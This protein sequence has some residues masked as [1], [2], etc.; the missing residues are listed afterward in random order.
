MLKYPRESFCH[1]VLFEKDILEVE[2]FCLFDQ[3][4]VKSRQAGL[5]LVSFLFVTTLAE[6][7][8]RTVFKPVI[9]ENATK[10][11][12]DVGGILDSQG[13]PLSKGE[14]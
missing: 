5:K 14:R 7:P 13:C 6:R 4:L 9:I 12:D 3:R 2:L 8:K 1:L 11:F 10:I